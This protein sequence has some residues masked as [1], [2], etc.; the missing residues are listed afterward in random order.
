VRLSRPIKGILLL[1]GVIALFLLLSMRIKF[2]DFANVEHLEDKI[3]SFGALAP[4]IY[5]VTMALAIVISP[6][7][8]MPLTAAAGMLWG[9]CVGT[10]YSV[11]GAE[12]G[13]IISF[14]IARNLG[15]AVIEK[16]LHRDIGFL[17][18]FSER[19][20]SLI[21]FISRLLPF[22]Q[23]DI[24]SYGAGLTRIRLRNFAL[25]TFFGMI[26]MSFLFTCCGRS[27]FI[28]N[29]LSALIS[30]V[31]IAIFFVAPVLIRKYN[32]FGLRD[33]IEKQTDQSPTKP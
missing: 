22:F 2:P 16:I 9:A 15:R 3:R 12:I 26:P 4:L 11:V 33:K 30:L 17:D 6:I 1:V 29:S 31:L 13:A 14:L 10:L 7:P 18:K 19:R 21:V 32:L 8:S 24:I 27:F 25:A 28:G 23:F 5:I 20:L